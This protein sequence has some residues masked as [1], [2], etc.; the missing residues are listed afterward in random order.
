MTG[1]LTRRQA[2][3]TIG[4]GAAGERFNK[5]EQAINDTAP[6]TIAGAA[7]KLRLLGHYQEEQEG[8]GGYANELLAHALAFVERLAGG[9]PS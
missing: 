4:A 3:T 6:I 1:P 9:T 8:E 5:V 7:V 2:L